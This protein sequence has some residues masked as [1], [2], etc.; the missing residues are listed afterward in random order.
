MR[1]IALCVLFLA[2]TGTGV[3]ASTARILYSDRMVTIENALTEANDLWVSSADVKRLLNGF[4][5]KPQGACFDDVCIPVKQNG[6]DSLVLIRDRKKLFNITAFARKLGQTYVAEARE[7][8]WSFGEIPVL[9]SSF[10]DSAIA[11]DFALPDR[12]G[13]TLRLSDFRGKKVLLLTW[14]SW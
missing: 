10:L 14:A 9:R 1:L 8:V 13:K 2:H 3:A 6:P 5:L 4:E 12:K 7:G 11:P